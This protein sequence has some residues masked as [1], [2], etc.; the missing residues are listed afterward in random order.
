MTYSV[1]PLIEDKGLSLLLSG[2]I[3]ALRVD[4]DS[5]TSSVMQ[6]VGST[7]RGYY[8]RGFRRNLDI[9]ESE[10]G[11]VQITGFRRIAIDYPATRTAG[12]YLHWGQRGYYP[13]GNLRVY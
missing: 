11:N 5:T 2:M 8:V 4:M 13:G 1:H 10:R 7:V 9:T 3:T 12:N 6:G